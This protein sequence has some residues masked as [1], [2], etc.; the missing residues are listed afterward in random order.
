[1]QSRQTHRHST[2][3]GSPK[4]PEQTPSPASVE[5]ITYRGAR[6][7]ADRHEPVAL[8]ER[9]KP[10]DPY[11][12]WL[13]QREAEREQ[14]ERPQIRW[15]HRPRIIPRPASG[16]RVPTSAPGREQVELERQPVAVGHDPV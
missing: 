12:A 10:V 2:R 3:D 14:L 1:V 6:Q 7:L 15:V 16:A 11:A 4:Q 13:E 5:P 8:T 9:A